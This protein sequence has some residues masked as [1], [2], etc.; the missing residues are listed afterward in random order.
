MA[1]SGASPGTP[2][3]YRSKIFAES[4]HPTWAAAPQRTFDLPLAE[5]PAYGGVSGEQ[6]IR[7][8]IGA[9]QGTGQAWT[10]GRDAL[11]VARIVDAAYESSRSGR[12]I[13]IATP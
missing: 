13:A 3:V 11:Q 7:D 4:I 8:F 12:R 1:N 2:L 5:S 10:T 6:F 9:A